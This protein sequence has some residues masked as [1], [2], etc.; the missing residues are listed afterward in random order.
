MAF[1]EIVNSQRSFFQ[2]QSTKTL[3][4]RIAQLKRMKECIVQHEEEIYA[5]IHADFGKSRFDTFTTEIAFLIKELDNYIKLLPKFIKPQRVSTNFFN[6]PGKSRMYNEP[7]GVCLVIGAWNYPFQLALLPAIAAL[8]AG[9]TVII[10]PSE[11]APNTAKLLEKLINSNFSANYAHVLIGDVEQTSE[12]LKQRF[13]HIFFTGSTRVGKIIY[14]AAAQ[15]L[16]PV[17]L[18][19]GGKS[20]AVVTSSANLKIAAKR[21]VWGKFLNAGQTCIAPDFVLLH[22]S[23]AHE[24][25]KQLTKYLEDFNY[26]IQSSH[27]TR[28][29]NEKHFKRLETLIMGKKPYYGNIDQLNK[30]Q[31][32]FPP[33]LLADA[34]W[35]DSCMQEEIFGPILPIIYFD[36]FDEILNTLIRLEKPLAAYLFSNNVVEKEKFT[37]YFSFGGG[38]INDTIMHISNSNLPFGGIGNSGIGKYHGKF[39]LETFSHR[40]SVFIKPTWEPALKYPPYTDSKFKLIKRLFRL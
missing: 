15:H 24:F 14:E 4:Y 32:Y 38:C 1:V 10:K 35:E 23:V 3:S 36:E 29:I 22:R 19:L 11:L 18:E 9:N 12:L 21:I 30:D 16:T 27:Y 8:A 13:D 20:P 40:K 5:A 34:K 39:S 33:I 7:L 17:T 37:K 6:L 2:S 31:L 25:L 28:I 26:A